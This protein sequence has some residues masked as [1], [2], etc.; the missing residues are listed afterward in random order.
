[1]LKLSD[2][3]Q[4]LITDIKVESAKRHLTDCVKPIV[5]RITVHH[6]CNITER[7]K[8]EGIQ[9]ELLSFAAFPQKPKIKIAIVFA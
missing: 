6:E 8:K 5:T 7:A 4:E 1:M 9:K 2:L 3:H